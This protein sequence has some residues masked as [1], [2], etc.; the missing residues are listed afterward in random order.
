M[1]KSGTTVSRWFDAVLLDKEQLDQPSNV[2]AVS[3]GDTRRTRRRA[4]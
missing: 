4:A 2:R 1:E 3:T